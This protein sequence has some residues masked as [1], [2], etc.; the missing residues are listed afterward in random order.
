MSKKTFH[1]HR[2]ERID[3]I[4]NQTWLYELAE[5]DI[6]PKEELN[7]FVV[8]PAHA[9]HLIDTFLISEGSARQNLATFCQTYMDPEAKTLIA[10]SLSKNSIDKTEYPQTAEIEERC[11]NILAKLWNAPGADFIGTSTI[12]SSE[13][14]QLA[15]MAMKVRWEEYAK[16]KKMPF[17]GCTEKTPNL[18]ISSAYQVCWEKFSTFW[19]VELREVP[20]TEDSLTLDVS[21]AI[22]AIDE[23]TIGIVPILG[24]TYT[25]SYD[26]I[27]RLDAA[28]EEYN[29]SAEHKIPIHV[30]GA[31]GAMFAPFTNKHLKWD[32][33]LK[34]VVSI[35]TSGHKYGLV[36]PGIGWVVWKE[37][38]FVPKKLS[39]DVSYLGGSLTTLGVNFSRSASQIIAQYYVFFRYG[40]SGMQEIHLK[41]SQ[42]A[43]MIC[44]RLKKY[45]LFDFYNEGTELPILCYKLKDNAD[46]GWTLYDL[47]DRLMMKGWQVPTYPLPSCL[48]EKI[49]QRIV[50]RADF[51]HSMANQLVDTF[52]EAIEVLNKAHVTV[53]ANQTD[54]YGFTH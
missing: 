1:T 28:V 26:D 34:N 6:L 3:R 16:K 51:S 22:D 18:I 45:D 7:D 49:V 38:S 44:E 2:K 8:P 47:S 14:C 27:E 52:D 21:A 17:G 29:K 37:K 12:G 25:G 24:V 50:C 30:D 42:V 9:A 31:S 33:R 43:Q 35:S 10:N 32:F 36:Y 53:H 54:S 39:F 15:G 11:I 41:T 13:A 20:L 19:D 4:A 48:E 40:F 5:G 23:Y 46:V